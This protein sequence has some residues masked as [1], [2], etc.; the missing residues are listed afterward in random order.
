MEKTA[1]SIIPSRLAIS[2]TEALLLEPK[3]RLAD[4]HQHHNAEH[5][6]GRTE[7]QA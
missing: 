6:A 4:G 7:Q 5:R 1:A 3:L 2:W